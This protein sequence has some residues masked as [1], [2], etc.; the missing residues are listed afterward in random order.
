MDVYQEDHQLLLPHR[1]GCLEKKAPCHH[2]E[3]LQVHQLHFLLFPLHHLLKIVCQ[4][5]INCL[6]QQVK[7]NKSKKLPLPQPFLLIPQQRRQEKLNNSPFICL[8]FRR[9]RHTGH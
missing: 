7:I 4:K 3:Y 2:Q 1:R 8:H 9:Y 5:E 6:F